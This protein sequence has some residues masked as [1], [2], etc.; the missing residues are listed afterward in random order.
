[1]GHPINPR[2][3]RLALVFTAVVA[4]AA[5]T[6]CSGLGD[7][8]ESGE[9]PG[10][11]AKPAEAE[12]AADDVTAGG[13]LAQTPGSPARREIVRTG[14]I[15]LAT[16]DPA[17]E[18]V[19]VR[20]LAGSGG[21]VGGERRSDG[22]ISVTLLVTPNR[23][24]ATL[25]AVGRLGEVTDRR[26]DTED[27]TARVVDLELRLEGARRKA[28]RLRALLDRAGSLTELIEVEKALGDVETEVERLESQQRSVRDRVDLAT[29]EVTLTERS[30][31]AA[32]G[33]IPGFSR[34][35]RTGAAAL[36]DI[37]RVAVTAIGFGLPFLAVLLPVGAVAKFVRHRPRRTAV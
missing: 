1:M 6:G 11:D 27:V 21:R 25:D 29:I 35:A 7:D 22:D 9:R 2:R 20:R 24:D 19:A 10:A 32:S 34:G 12:V 26:V 36:A 14:A 5:A 17:D 23:F 31:P 28:A 4:I 16:D 37:A 18:V 30:E 33:D 13:P 8:A 15:T 3:L